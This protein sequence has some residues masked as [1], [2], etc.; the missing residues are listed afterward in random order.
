MCGGQEETGAVGDR[1]SQSSERRREGRGTKHFGPPEV[2]AFGS[3]TGTLAQEVLSFRSCIE[4][5]Q[6]FRFTQPN[7]YAAPRDVQRIALTLNRA[8]GW[9]PLGN[10]SMGQST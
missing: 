4:A 5:L 7:L 9:I 10:H 6:P 8:A 2:V 1:C 3:Q